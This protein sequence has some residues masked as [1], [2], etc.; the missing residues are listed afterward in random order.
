MAASLS[1]SPDDERV[2]IGSVLDGRYR[3]DALLGTGGMGRVY[4]GEHTGLPPRAGNPGS[5][6]GVKRRGR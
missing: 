2:S 1:P 5:R 3:I 6:V 4:R